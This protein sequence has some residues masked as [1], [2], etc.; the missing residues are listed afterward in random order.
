MSRVTMS[1]PITTCARCGARW[2]NHVHVLFVKGS[3]C[4]ACQPAVEIMAWRHHEEHMSRIRKELARSMATGETVTISPTPD[5]ELPA[6]PVPR[7]P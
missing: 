4:R 3:I 2:H 7:E 6:P 5:L 1:W